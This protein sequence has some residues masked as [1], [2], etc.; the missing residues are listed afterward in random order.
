MKTT[1]EL[2]ERIAVNPKVMVRKPVLYAVKTSR[3]KI[4][5]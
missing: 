1:E 2:L 5:E 3:R 4:E